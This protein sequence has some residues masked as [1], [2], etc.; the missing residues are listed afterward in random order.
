MK[1]LCLFT[2]FLGL[3]VHSNHSGIFLNHHK[4]T[5]NLITLAGLQDTS[6]VD[7]P[8]EVNTKYLRDEGDLLSESYFVSTVDEKFKLFDD[9][10]S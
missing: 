2:Y 6:S 9:Y 5:Q 10:S 7:T 3:E 4:Y 1:D 8:L